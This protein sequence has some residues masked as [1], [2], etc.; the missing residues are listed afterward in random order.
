[1]FLLANLR[2]D[3]CK[4]DSQFYGSL[5]YLLILESPLYAT[6][7]ENLEAPVTANITPGVLYTKPHTT[8]N[9]PMVSGNAVRS[10]SAFHKTK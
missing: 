8:K 5:W 3:I 9:K 1:M 6:T 4:N 7:L 2:H 10:G